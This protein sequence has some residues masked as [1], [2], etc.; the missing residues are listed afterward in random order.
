MIF[1]R[2]VTML[3][4]VN[5]LSPEGLQNKFT[6]ISAL[7]N[8]KT[9]NMKNMHV[10]KLKLAHT[11]R[12]FLYTA[13]NAWNSIPQAIRSADTIAR[14]KRV[15]ISPFELKKHYSSPNLHKSMEDQQ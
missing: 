8:Y 7:S 15:E 3:K 13:P 14:F 1:D 11:K 5:I 9:R 12:T 10:Q 6:E 4:I 2:A